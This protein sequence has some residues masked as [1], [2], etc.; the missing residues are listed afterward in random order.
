MSIHKFEA[1]AFVRAR[2]GGATRT[3][4]ARAIKFLFHVVECRGLVPMVAIGCRVQRI[5]W[6]EEGFW[7]GEAERD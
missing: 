4:G 7:R 1:V 2:A 6:A 5:S 3:T